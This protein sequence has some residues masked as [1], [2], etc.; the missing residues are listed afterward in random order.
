MVVNFN[1]GSDPL[2][3]NYQDDNHQIYVNSYGVIQNRDNDR[4]V[5]AIEIFVAWYAFEGSIFV[6]RFPRRKPKNVEDSETENPKA[7]TP[8]PKKKEV[9][10]NSLRKPRKPV[11]KNGK[12]QN[13]APEID[14]P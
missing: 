10:D 7:P 5:R 13:N 1:N 8:K 9:V 2:T 12:A 11:A 3:V 6:V 14:K 4:I